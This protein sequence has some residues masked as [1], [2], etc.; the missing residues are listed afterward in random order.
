[1]TRFAKKSLLLLLVVLLVAAFA[2]SCGGEKGPAETTD[3]TV[4]DPAVTDP[5]VTDPIVTDPVVT[6]PVIAPEKPEI[7]NYEDYY[8]LYVQD[9][10]LYHMS[11]ASATE[12][13]ALEYGSYL[14][15]S[16]GIKNAWSD[17]KSATLGDGYLNLQGEVN[18]L[19]SVASRIK[20][21]YSVEVVAAATDIPLRLAFWVGPR[22]DLHVGTSYQAQFG[23]G[24]WGG[25][26]KDPGQL[27]EGET[28]DYT[29]STLPVKTALD[30]TLVNTYTFAFD[31]SNIAENS[32]YNFNV[33][34]NGEFC[35]ERL[36]ILSTKN[37]FTGTGFLKVYNGGVKIYAVRVYD[38]QLSAEEASLNHF[39]DI[40]MH[41]GFDLT[42]FNALDDAKKASVCKAMEFY[43]ADEDYEMLAESFVDAMAAV[44]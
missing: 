14:V 28:V 39:I 16:N 37:A 40:A 20:T 11:F 3:P 22:Y 24:A 32:K 36:N 33:Y 2:C 27:A 35:A 13:K 19:P 9:G 42:E 4:T 43:A 21:G 10:L 1:M 12:S 25:M 41:N 6:D 15:Y 18:I 34:A 7:I 29:I 38:R 17:G 23:L 8:P 26:A 44:K 5:V 30:G 31:L